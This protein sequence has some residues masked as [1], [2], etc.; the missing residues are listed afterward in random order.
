MLFP[1]RAE[2]FLPGLADSIRPEPTEQARYL[3]ALAAPLLGALAVAGSSRWLARVPVRAIA[4][5]ELATQLILPC[6]VAAAMIAQYRLHM[7]A[8]YTV[9]GE[10]S[11]TVR[12]FTPATLVVAA[13]LAAATAAVAGMPRLRVRAAAG[14]LAE[15]RRRRWIVG[16]IALAAT[17]IWMLHA[18]HSDDEIANAI[19]DIGYH[20]SFVLDET[21]SVLNGRTP[22]VNFSAQYSSL[23]PFVIAL[24]LLAFGKTALTFTIVMCTLTTLALLAV[25]G[26]LRRASG[27]A[28]AA[29]LLYLPL[30]ATSLYMIDGTRQDRES[31]GTFYG[32]MPLRYAVPFFVAW[33][34]ARLLA[35]R[36][37]PG[38]RA[39][40]LLFAV[41]GLGVLNNSE[42]GIAA[43]GGALAALLWTTER[44]ERRALL[45]LAGLAAAGLATALA[46][47]A[48]LTL[49]RA[50]ELPQLWRL[51]EFAR[52][53]AVGGFAM[54]RIPSVLGVPLL[55]YLTYVAAIVVATVRRVRGACNSV[56]TGMLAWAGVFGLGAG[57]YYV[58]RSHPYTLP[59]EFSAWAL[60][61]ALLMIVAVRE[62]AGAS[63]RRN[64][65]GALVVLFGFGVAACSLAQTPTPWEQL[66]RLS[67]PFVPSEDA[68]DPH[69]LV[70]PQDAAARA[71]VATVA[72][73]R[74]FVY[75]HGAPV[76]ILLT[77]GHRIADAY[78]V[79]D[80]APYTGVASLQTVERVDRVIDALRRAGGNTVIVPAG[81]RTG[82]YDVLA[83]HGFSI[84][85]AGG[86]GGSE[87]LV[88]P[89]PGGYQLMKWVDTRHSLPRALR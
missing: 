87:P 63:P 26:V 57:S 53:F 44:F 59:H 65:V 32:T 28:T 81:V 68:P 13:L 6:L 41:A 88:Q 85:R 14:L 22:L 24:P 89:W 62:L 29:L 34:T 21:F 45:R 58:G 23:W 16:A 83:R 36:E 77:T 12:Y 73:G 33:L 56:L 76:A 30:L 64:A 74:R 43:F 52:T 54:M 50:D 82:I 10:A 84:V 69:P 79:V 70:P 51:T 66:A 42:F 19:E 27:S 55:V 35:R 40:W 15:S 17:A 49:A 8:P 5:L 46:L 9:E 48:L 37:S 25:Y 78:G 2:T 60:A 80:V 71:F 72:D 67:A 3:I 47:V 31:A 86:A 75:R 20:L 4:P 11:L 39:T 18:V 61:L 38:A 7:G 1:A